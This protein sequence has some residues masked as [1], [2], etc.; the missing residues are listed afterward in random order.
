MKKNI[1][2]LT[3]FILG[4]SSLWA[5]EETKEFKLN[6]LETPSDPAFIIMGNSNTEI[7]TPSNVSDLKTSLQNATNNFSA[8]PSN[9]A[10]SIAPGWLIN[11]KAIS[12][13][14][15]LNDNSVIDNVW[16]SLQLS[17]GTSV[18]NQNNTDFRRMGAGLKFALY[19]GE[20]AERTQ[21]KFRQYLQKVHLNIFEET[22][23]EKQN[24]ALYKKLSQELK[25]AYIKNDSAQISQLEVQLE[26][27]T[28]ALMQKVSDNLESSKNTD[29][30]ILT[31][32]KL[33]RTG[34]FW[35]VSGAGAMNFYNKNL[36]SSDLYRWGAWTNF[37]WKGDTNQFIFMARYL[38][39]T[40]DPFVTPTEVI[41]SVK[42]QSLDF[43]LKYV[44][45]PTEKF[46]VSGEGIYRFMLDEGMDQTYK[47]MVNFAYD[48]GKNQ[49]INLALGRDFE[50]VYTKKASGLMYL[51]Y[52]I[53]FGNERKLKG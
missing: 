25:E 19:R 29:L 20:V 40:N 45:N 13:E 37:G 34:F 22:Q 7:E 15:Y 51:S 16:Q 23:K 32:I 48:V 43:G 2:L 9:Y 11:G 14:R 27:R 3:L 46:K 12:Y 4:F 42:Y 49:I 21:N 41:D 5:Q 6:L 17:L 50:G 35:D 31:D 24:D 39:F 8:L 28:E 1:K 18:L 36:D 47:F 53:G 44:W 26:Q 30:K 10:L 33:E 38:S 52:I